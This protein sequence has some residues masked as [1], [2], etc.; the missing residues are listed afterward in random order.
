MSKE[1]K[2]VP[3]VSTVGERILKELYVYY[4]K[5]EHRK[6]FYISSLSSCLRRAYYEKIFPELV[7]EQIRKSTFEGE[8][9]HYFVKY[10]VDLGGKLLFEKI[11]AEVPVEYEFEG[12]KI[13]GRADI[14]LKDRIIE[15]KTCRNIPSRPYFS[16]V[17]QA[18]AYA[19]L[20]KKKMFEVTYL[21]MHN[22]RSFVYD[23]SKELFE[24]LLDRARILRKAL[25]FSVAPEREP[26]P[27]C[28][29]CPYYHVCFRQMQLHL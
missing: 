27:L 16:H 23:T 4:R 22:I 2:L 1:Y 19:Y 3:R 5:Q 15:L 28:V 21:G 26:S 18:N 9:I 11:N 25:I 14:V 20:L 8:A 6:G 29:K 12:I 24:R 10:L 7:L 17:L 13:V